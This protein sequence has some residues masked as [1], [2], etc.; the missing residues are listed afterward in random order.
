MSDLGRRSL[1]DLGFPLPFLLLPAVVEI[2]PFGLRIVV[3]LLLGG[4]GAVGWLLR[5][6]WGSSLLTATVAA[7][8]IGLASYP[9]ELSLWPRPLIVGCLLMG[10]WIPQILRPAPAPR[11]AR[12][13]PILLGLWTLLTPA[14]KRYDVD[15]LHPELLELAAGLNSPEELTQFVHEQISRKKAP[16]TDTAHDTWERKAGHCGAMSNLL[17]KLLIHRNWKAS[18]FHLKN[19][20]DDLHTLIWIQTEN[21]SILA[22][23]QENLVKYLE[24]QELVGQQNPPE[25]WPGT[26]LL[27]TR[28]WIH[29]PGRGYTPLAP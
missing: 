23:P 1:F 17:H 24:P 15:A 14:A 26:W 28:A 12:L 11:V 18:I 7:G 5:T 20:E 25:D 21:G 27:H 19:A 2:L 6:S 13:I 22:D 4:A 16:P 3:V 8:W 10:I 29:Q 9:A